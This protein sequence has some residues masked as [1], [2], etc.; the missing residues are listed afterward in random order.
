VSDEARVNGGVIGPNE[1]EEIIAGMLG[2]ISKLT[3]EATGGT[4]AIV[5]HPLAPGTLAAPM[6]THT[7]EDEFSFVIEGEVG[8]RF[9]DR[10]MVATAGSYIVKPRGIPHT[11]WNAA[12]RPARLLEIISP[13]G[14]EGYFRE[15]AG[16]LA[17]GGEPDFGAIMALAGRYGLEMHPESIGEISAK[18]GVRLG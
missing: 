6:H 10:E 8:V 3:G 16:I 2:V 5:E 1:G 13:A 18:H 17:Q 11:F 12:D 9:G 4:F 14:F 7:R 15:L